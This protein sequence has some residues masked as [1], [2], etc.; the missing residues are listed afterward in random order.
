[1]NDGSYHMQY[2][3]VCEPRPFLDRSGLTDGHE[4]VVEVTGWKSPEAK[5]EGSPAE[6][7]RVDD[8]W[9]GGGVMSTSMHAM[10]DVYFSS[11][12]HLV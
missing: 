11:S 1:M 3:D 4:E 8:P 6:G 2:E 5:D 12:Y 10:Q 9:H 7:P